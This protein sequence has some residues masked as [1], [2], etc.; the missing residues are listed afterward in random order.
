MK[1]FKIYYNPQI[2]IAITETRIPKNVSV[3][4]NIVLHN[5]SIEH[6]LTESSAGATLQYIAYRLSYKIR[7]DLKIHKKFELESDFIEI[8]NPGKSNIIVGAMYNTTI[9]RKIFG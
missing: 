4:Q 5:Y 8:I 1:N 3:T 6:T 9:S 7:N 2:L